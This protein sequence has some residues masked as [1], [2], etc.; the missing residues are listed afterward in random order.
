LKHSPDFKSKE[1]DTA[2]D[3][4]DKTKARSFS[5]IESAMDLKQGGFLGFGKTDV[6]PQHPA[7]RRAMEDRYQEFFRFHYTEGRDVTIAKANAISDLQRSYNSTRLFGKA[8]MMPMPPER[9]YPPAKPLPDGKDISKLT[10]A[11]Y[12]EHYGYIIDQAMAAARQ[13]IDPKVRDKLTPADVVLL[14]DN[15]TKRDIEARQ[16]PR[17]T[18]AYRRGGEWFVAQREFQANPELA[19]ARPLEIG[20]EAAMFGAAV[21]QGAGGTPKAP[22]TPEQESARDRFRSKRGQ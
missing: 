16:L 1:R 14:P 17:Y 20:E 22:S 5:E 4:A 15:L 18:L 12:K 13:R 9:N 21:A 10:D 2:K 3:I 11:E 8:Y 7:L 6:G 19:L